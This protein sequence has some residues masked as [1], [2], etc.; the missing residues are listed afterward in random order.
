[1]LKKNTF[2]SFKKSRITGKHKTHL[3]FYDRFPYS[4]TDRSKQCK[5]FKCS[6]KN[7]EF[8]NTVGFFESDWTMWEKLHEVVRY[9]TYLNFK[10]K[11]ELTLSFY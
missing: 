3:L 8:L 6:K 4:K 1:M 7:Q 2:S 9:N 11:V 10:I 5:I